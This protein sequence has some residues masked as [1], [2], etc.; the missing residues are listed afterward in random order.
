M[1]SIAILAKNYLL[2]R[3]PDCYQIRPAELSKF[4]KGTKLASSR[5]VCKECYKVVV[6]YKCVFTNKHNCLA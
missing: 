5:Y 6:L 1:S 2:S 3:G 4:F